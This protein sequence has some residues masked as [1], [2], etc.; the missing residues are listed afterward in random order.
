[1]KNQQ[2]MTGTFTIMEGSNEEIYEIAVEAQADMIIRAWRERTRADHALVY[3]AFP[4][5]A[6]FEHAVDDDAERPRFLLPQA[7]RGE[8]LL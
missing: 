3:E 8:D 6:G 4:A 2:M 5:D 7:L 1:M